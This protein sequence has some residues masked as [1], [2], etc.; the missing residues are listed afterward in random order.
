MKLKCG[1]CG[2]STEVVGVGLNLQPDRRGGHNVI[3]EPVLVAIGYCRVLGREVH[4]HLRVGVAG[5][6]PASQRVRTEG[7]LPLKLE[8]PRARVRLARLGRPALELG[9]A[10]NGHVCEVAKSWRQIKPSALGAAVKLW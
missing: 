8:Q 3:A 7:L 9:D 4:P 5:A 6:I 2:A 1:A 10:G